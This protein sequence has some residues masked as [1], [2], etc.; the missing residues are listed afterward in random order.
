[1]FLKCTNKTIELVHKNLNNNNHMEK[2]VGVTIYILL[3][4]FWSVTTY[5]E[6]NFI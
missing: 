3:V 2:Y 4:G 6:K 1:M 5:N